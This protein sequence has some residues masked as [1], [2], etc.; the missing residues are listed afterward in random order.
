M[1]DEEEWRVIDGPVIYEVSSFG[2]VRRVSRGKSTMPGKILSV[3]PRK[4]DGYV[5]V[6]LSY[7][8]RGVHR[9]TLVHILVAEAFHGPK[10]SPDHEVAH[11]DGN[12]FNNRADNLRWATH[13]ENMMDM[14]HKVHGKATF[15]ERAWAAKLTEKEVIE[16]RAMKMVH[17][18]LSRIARE[19]GVTGTTIREAIDGKTWAYLENQNGV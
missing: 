19:K 3:R 2:R 6:V 18:D 15:G 9:Q 8:A 16:L 13:A 14:S 17:G 12:C 7:G 5:P 10:P 4:R 1:Q 11:C